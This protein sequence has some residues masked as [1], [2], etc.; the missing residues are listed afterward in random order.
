MESGSGSAPVGPGMGPGIAPSGKPRIS[1]M[2]PGGSGWS[3]SVTLFSVQGLTHV[4]TCTGGIGGLRKSKRITR[5]H[6]DHPDPWRIFA[7][8]ETRRPGPN[9][10]PHPDPHGPTGPWPARD[11]DAMDAARPDTDVAHPIRGPP[12]WGRVPA[13]PFASSRKLRSCRTT[14]SPPIDMTRSSR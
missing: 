2:G 11:A 8:F 3:G 10:D 6:P 13:A 7:V 14:P 5:T 12:R 9:P 4:I 1:W